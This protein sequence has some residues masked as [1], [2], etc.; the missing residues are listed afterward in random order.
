[1][2]K[3]TIEI[4]LTKC[5][6]LIVDDEIESSG[7]GYCCII[8]C[9]SGAVNTLSEYGVSLLIAK[10]AKTVLLGFKNNLY[11][12]IQIG[13]AI[14]NLRVKHIYDMIS[15]NKKISS[16]NKVKYNKEIRL[17]KIDKANICDYIE[18]YND[19]FK[20][21]PNAAIYKDEDIL[22]LLNKK[23]YDIC[24]AYHKQ[25]IVGVCEYQ[26]SPYEAVI[27]AIGVSENHRHKGYAKIILN[28]LYYIFQLENIK[29][30]TLTTSTFNKKIVKFYK[31]QNFSNAK[32]LSSWYIV[33]D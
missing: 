16:N 11:K 5:D 7:I 15:M 14:G 20:N 2:Y 31:H 3:K 33:L 19:I 10:G 1:M 28:N 29:N 32:M 30:I 9:P 27:E 12:P 25:E 22:K 8:K 26:T 18:L 23:N 13:N 4:N 24:F 21:L 6:I 17:K